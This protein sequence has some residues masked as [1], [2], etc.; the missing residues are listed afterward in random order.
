MTFKAGKDKKSN[1]SI[2]KCGNN[3]SKR[4]KLYRETLQG[5]NEGHGVQ[6]ILITNRNPNSMKISSTSQNTHT[7]NFM[8][9]M[10][11][12]IQICVRFQLK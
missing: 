4:N 10:N 12:M 11:L 1:Y 8:Q 9:G 2:R 7:R 3:Y 6:E 5:L